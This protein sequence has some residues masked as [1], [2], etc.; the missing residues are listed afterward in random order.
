MYGF[1]THFNM[2]QIENFINYCFSCIF[3]FWPNDCLNICESFPN[4]LGTK[5]KNKLLVA[6]AIA[7]SASCANV[8]AE[9]VL[10]HG[11]SLDPLLNRDANQGQG[12]F[13][14][15]FDFVQWWENDGTPTSISAINAGNFSDF[16][17]TGYGKLDP[18]DATSG[19]GEFQCRSTCEITFDFSGIG[20]GIR[21]LQPTEIGA[22]INANGQALVDAGFAEYGRFNNLIVTDEDGAIDFLIASGIL[23]DLGNDVLGT[24]DLALDSDSLLNIWVDYDPNLVVE[25]KTDNSIAA[26]DG[27]VNPWLT[28]NFQEVFYFSGA[29]DDGVLGLSRADTNFGLVAVGGDA[30]DNFERAED[31]RY[32]SEGIDRLSD[33]IGFGLSGSFEQDT[34]GTFD[35]YSVVGDGAVDGNVVAAPT[36]IA[37]F[38]LSLAGMGLLSRRRKA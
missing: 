34:N 19:Q 31:I 16:E 8:S 2:L 9:I 25:D 12:N 1:F 4:Q 20:L 11:L 6:L 22:R 23:L 30:L 3:V 18:Y 38:G 21:E 32:P 14:H 28:L 7:A 13:S 29:L 27:S 15:G 17:L 5:M 33:V 26:I 10:P 36:M 35:V 37:L 24:L